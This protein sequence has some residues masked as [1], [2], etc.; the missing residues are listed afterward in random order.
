MANK[1]FTQ[2]GLSSFASPTDF[3]V[4]YDS[5]GVQEL[6]YN[7]SDIRNTTYALGLLTAG[8]FDFKIRG[9]TVGNG[10]GA[11]SNNGNC[12][13]GSDALRFAGNSNPNIGIGV[14]AGY[15][16][17]SSQFNIAIGYDAMKFYGGNGD[18]NIGI[19][20]SALVNANGLCQK[21]VAI[22][23]SNVLRNI[24][25]SSSNV[26]IGD[27][28]GYYLTGG[29]YNT[30][31]G[32][33]VGA[34]VYEGSYNTYVGHYA[35]FSDDGPT[36]VTGLG[37]NSQTT[38]DNQVQLGNSS[39]TTY[40]Y[41]TVQ[42]RSDIRDKADVR[43]TVLG[44]D[45]IMA[46]R[47]V[48]YKWDLREDYKTTPPENPPAEATEEELENYNLQLRQ[49][50]QSNNINNLVHD[51]THKRTRYH[52]GLIAQEVKQML[53]AKGIDFGGYQDHAIKGG[54]DVQSIGYDE[55]VAPLIKAIQQLK[56]EFD[57]YK[58]SHP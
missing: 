56:Q 13:F 7:A 54:K 33:A 32:D 31:I 27:F 21:N 9:L 12:A 2:F 47:P 49:W 3:I 38:G 22:G 14:S 44:L 30:W 25:N 57:E 50:A 35:G 39:T 45:F 51:G 34:F 1:N 55:L 10:P 11:S 37:Y 28:T 42:N 46:L 58:A 19:G 40:V 18:F 53:D 41:G 17:S 52:H 4:G 24:I 43:D 6:R 48:D 23:A 26:A 29:D 16:L 8:N 5:T 15:A 20:S 36:N